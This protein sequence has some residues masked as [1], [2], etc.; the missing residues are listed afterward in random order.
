MMNFVLK[1]FS[2]YAAVLAVLSGCTPK[3]T[4]DSIPTFNWVESGQKIDLS[5][6]QH[7]GARK[8]P[9]GKTVNANG[10][11]AISDTTVL[12]TAAIQAAIDSCHNA[13]GGTVTLDPGSYITGALFIKGGVN[14]EI[15]KGVTLYAS[16]DISHYPEFRT[17][18]AGI[19]MVWPS[20][21]L[22]IIDAENAAISGEGT[23]D[24]QGKVFWDTY[25]NMRKAYEKEQLRWIVDYDCKRV[26]GIL[27]SNSSDITLKAFTLMRT[28]FWGVQVLYS[29]HCTVDGLTVNNN[30]G[31]HG[32]STDGIDI[33]SSTFIL[34][35]N[36]DVDCNDDNI[37]IKAG[38][39][40]DGLRVNRPTEYVV[41]RNCIARKG[42]GLITCGSETSGSIRYVLG[43]NLQ[44]YGT[45]AALRIKSAL[46]RG[47]TVENI[48]MTDVK[49]DSIKSILAADLNWNPSYSYS[50]LPPQ[51]EGKEI[52]EHWKVML[53]PVEPKEKGYP[54]FKNVY[55]A[56]VKATHADQFISASGW[57]DSLRL[58]NF[59]LYHIE[60][61]VKKAGK[62]VLTKGF[63][64]KDIKLKT[65]DK[66]KITIEDNK[67]LIMDVDYE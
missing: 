5:W 46:N 14:L 15:G 51:F 27:I 60:A 41:V 33:D 13:G 1:R 48:F 31:G 22:N 44:A 3:L 25:W 50:L 18:V 63:S 2:M 56:N 34:V 29:D 45:S 30:I 54:Y 21:V 58:E 67:Q 16:T 17:R 55:L 35:E 9:G 12:S 49:A 7:V 28:G 26:R 20:A 39:D 36:C 52:P 32:P 53:T 42:A 59:Q 57:N 62:I 66:N 10:F 65:E 8:F 6:A 43:Y 38:R 61:E 11:G 37:C 64:L 47:G 4:K 19:E 23:I 24:C 40:A